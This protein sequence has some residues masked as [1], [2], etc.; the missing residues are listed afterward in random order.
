MNFHLWLKNNYKTEPAPDGQLRI[1]CPFCP[2][3]DK[4]FHLYL[5]PEG[6]G[7]CHRCNTRFG[8]AVWAVMKLK[9][10][11]KREAEDILKSD[12]FWNPQ[13]HLREASLSQY[14][15]PPVKEINIG[16][17]V[18]K[19]LTDRGMTYQTINQWRLRQIDYAKAVECNVLDEM[20]YLR[21]NMI[22]FPIF[23]RRGELVYYQLR[24]IAEKV[25]WNPSKWP[26]PKPFHLHN[27]WNLVNKG[28][29]KCVLVEGFFD[30]FSLDRIGV[31]SVSLLGTNLSREQEELLIINFDKFYVWLDPDADKHA[32]DICRQLLRWKPDV[33]MIKSDLEPDD[34][35]RGGK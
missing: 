24:E 10:C 7:F 18:Y 21:N 1:N 29:R 25:F 34:Y 23:G 19:Y 13:A 14:I 3:I 26:I 9:N 30:T 27:L 16:D 6:K 35:V 28:I 22:F 2:K 11:N 4:K 20:P 17:D 31:H 12:T 32:K 15:I 5:T 33:T 8:N